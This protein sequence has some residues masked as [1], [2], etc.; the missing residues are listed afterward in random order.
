MPNPSSLTHLRSPSKSANLVN[1][2]ASGSTMRQSETCIVIQKRRWPTGERTA[3]EENV[4]FFV[5]IK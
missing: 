2:V 4:S 1:T 3:L 5:F